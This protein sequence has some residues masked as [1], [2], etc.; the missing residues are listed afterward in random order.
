MTDIVLDARTRAMTVEELLE[1]TALGPV[2][3]LS[4]DGTP[5]G[6]LA[7]ARPFPNGFHAGVESSAPGVRRRDDRPRPDSISG[8]DLRAR[9]R[10]LDAAR[11]G[12]P[13]G[14]PA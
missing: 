5:L 4:P 11:T 14:D 8:D 2:R 3:L 10:A 9:W 7:A 12:T 13:G 6:E 1:R